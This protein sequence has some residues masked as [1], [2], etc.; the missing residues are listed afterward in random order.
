MSTFT[1]PI[2]Q[3]MKNNP[4]YVVGNIDKNLKMSIGMCPACSTSTCINLKNNQT[5][6]ILSKQAA[7][8]G[9][10]NGSAS[11]ASKICNGKTIKE[12]CLSTGCYWNPVSSGQQ[13]PCLL[14]SCT[15]KIEGMNCCISERTNTVSSANSWAVG[16]PLPDSGLCSPIDIDISA[17]VRNA[18][19]YPTKTNGSSSNCV[20]LG[21]WSSLPAILFYICLVLLCMFIYFWARKTF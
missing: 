8:P 1:R 21:T 17:A 16:Q 14:P 19:W 15:S 4:T 13:S 5:C 10:R 20:S 11:E 7:T 3:S 2:S 18:G 12:D 6:Q 9:G